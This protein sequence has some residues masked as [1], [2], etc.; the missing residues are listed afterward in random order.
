L[1]AECKNIGGKKE[2]R[3]YFERFYSFCF[4][5][6]VDLMPQTESAGFLINAIERYQ[7][8]NPIESQ[9]NPGKYTVRED[10]FK[11]YKEPDRIF[12][13]LK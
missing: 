5:T 1:E 7:M 4:A 8:Q 13:R 11:R 6:Y 2:Q 12:S 3:Q 9:S 10:T